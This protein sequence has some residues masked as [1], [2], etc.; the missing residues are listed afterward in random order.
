MVDFDFCKEY[1]FRVVFYI[2]VGCLGYFNV[3]CVIKSV[4]IL[5]DNFVEGRMKRRIDL[6]GND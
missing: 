6:L 1:M 3:R 5:R 4:E 2:E